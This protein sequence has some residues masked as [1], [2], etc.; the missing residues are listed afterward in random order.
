[1]EEPSVH[2]R[3]AYADDNRWAGYYPLGDEPE[4]VRSLLRDTKALAKQLMQ[5]QSNQIIDGDT[6][7]SHLAPEKNA[8]QKDE[9][10]VIVK[11]KI[12]LSGEITANGEKVTLAELGTTLDE[13]KQENGG[14]WYFRESPEE[15]P[16][17]SLDP[18][19]EAVLDA[20]TSRS[21]PV[22]LQPEEY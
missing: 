6:A 18:T 8:A 10:S 2:I 5:K 17:K 11:V 14:V 13:L 16:P 3:L 21:L 19:I 15:E 22:R 7:H 1:M 4:A 12:H 9:P 20:I